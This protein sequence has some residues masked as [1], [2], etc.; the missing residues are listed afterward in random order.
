M[1]RLR[2]NKADLSEAITKV[3][4]L[5]MELWVKKVNDDD[6]AIATIVANVAEVVLRGWGLHGPAHVTSLD[7]R[8]VSAHRD[9][10][11]Q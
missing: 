11:P 10:R 8:M 6:D 1:I 4:G 9:N 7:Q 2:K 5:S 3:R